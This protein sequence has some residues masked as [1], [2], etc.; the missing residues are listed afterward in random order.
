MGFLRLRHICG[1]GISQG[2]HSCVSPSRR[3]GDDS[4]TSDR[5]R[6]HAMGLGAITK[7]RALKNPQRCRSQPARG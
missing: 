5:C 6:A 1:A 2:L 3:D 7:R 4:M